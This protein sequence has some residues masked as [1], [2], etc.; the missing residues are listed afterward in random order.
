MKT[1]KASFGNWHIQC[2][3]ADG[4]RISVLRYKD[5]DLLTAKPVSFRAPDTF[6]GEYETRPVYG[7]DD[8]FPTCTPCKYPGD[9]SKCRDHGELCWNE[10]ELDLTGNG[11]VCTTDCLKPEVRFI[12]ILEFAGNRLTWKFEVVNRSAE[13]IVFLHLMHALLPLAE[14]QYIKLPDFLNITEENKHLDPSL[15]NSSDV[16]KHLL[17]LEPGDYEM[18]LLNEIEEVSVILGFHSG[19]ALNMEYNIKMFPTLGIWWN[20][21]GYPDEEGLRRT[22]CAFEPIPGTSSDLS[23]SFSDESYLSAE[24]GETIRWEISWSVRND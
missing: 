8:C 11:M 9:Q 23:R 18:L 24:P 2:I 16:E 21:A 3:P 10:W 5:Q 4:G 20:N 13:K 19:L 7:Y 14:I 1:I 15:K 12:R 17:S 22:E 6:Y